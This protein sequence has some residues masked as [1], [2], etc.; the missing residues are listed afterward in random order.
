MQTQKT[1]VGSYGAENTSKETQ[2]VSSDSG[3]ELLEG[4][5]PSLH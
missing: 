5:S 1:A 2:A 4:C 3:S